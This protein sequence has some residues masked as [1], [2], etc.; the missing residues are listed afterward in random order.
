MRHL[1][2]STLALL[3][4]LI[5][6]TGRADD[7]SFRADV[8]A[9]T[10]GPHRLTG[11]PENAHA[12]DRIVE[13]L[14]AIGLDQ[15]FTQTFD[16]SQTVVKRCD[17]TLDGATWTLE[18]MRPNGIIP[19]TTPAA[20]LTGTLVDV[21]DGRLESYPATLPAGP[22]IMVMDFESGDA[23]RSAFRSG[24]EAVI[25]VRRGAMTSRSQHSSFAS[26]N[27][28]RFF[29]DGDPATL[30]I[31][32]SA[33]LHSEV[34]WDAA[35][36]RNVFGFLP[37]TDPVFDPATGAEVI[38]LAAPLDSFG[39]VP[40][41]SPGARPAA[42]CAAM[43]QLAEHLQKNRPRRH[44]LFA[45]FDSEARGH[46]GANAFYRLLDK[47]VPGL[48][49]AKR[50]AS[51]TAE[52]AFLTALREL[53]NRPGNPLADYDLS[54]DL[55]FKLKPIA[56]EH[57]YELMNQLSE[58]RA[59]RDRL[60]RVEQP[61]DAVNAQIDALTADKD[62]WN[63]T[64]RVIARGEVAGIAEPLAARL[65][66]VYGELD[67]Q[68]AVRLTQIAAMQSSI[69]LDQQLVDLLGPF[70][71]TLHLSMLLDD[72]SSRWG[73]VIGDTSLLA[74]NQDN[75]GLYTRVQS[76]FLK[77]ANDLAATQALTS[78]EVGSANQA[79]VP[80]H[81]ILGTSQFT[82]S[83]MVAGRLGLYNAALGTVQATFERDGT[84]DDTLAN[85]NLDRM[86]AQFGDMAPLLQGLANDPE[87]SMARSVKRQAEYVYS[88]F[89]DGRLTGPRALGTTRGSSVPT[90]PLDGAMIQIMTN[91]LTLQTAHNPTMIPAY[92]DFLVLRTDANGSYSYGPIGPAD[93][94]LSYRGFAVS[95]DP[96]GNVE[97]VNSQGTASRHE[98]RFNMVTC[99]PGAQML[100][101][102]FA[103]RD[104]KV[105]DG[106]TNGDLLADKTN[107]LTQ[108]G[109][110]GWYAEESTSK[111]KLFEVKTI[112]ALNNGPANLASSD[113]APLGADDK[114]GASNDSNGEGLL[115]DHS[116]SAEP[117]AIAAQT[118][119]DL[120]RLNESRL[121][122]LRRRGIMNSSMEELHGRAEDLLLESAA[123]TDPARRDALANS[124]F[125][126][127]QRT[128]GPIRKT[129]DDIVKAVLILLAL[130]VPFAFALERLLIGTPNIYRQIS[131]FTG[132]FLATFLLLYI[133]HPA[134]A[135]SKTPVVIFLGFTIVV[136]S[137]MVIVIIMQKFEQELKVLQGMESTVH[138]ADV[139]RFSTIM[140]AMSMGISTMRRRPLRT[141]LTATTIILLT[142]T[143]LGFASFETQRG[144]NTR[145]AQPSPTYSGAF[146]HDLNWN[147][148]SADI[149]EMIQGRWHSTGTLARRYW[150][151]PDAKRSKHLLLTHDDGT[152]PLMMTGL[153]GLDPQEVALR[154][155]LAAQLKP[156]GLTFDDTIWMTASAARQLGVGVG[157][158]VRINGLSLTV[159]PLL[160]PIKLTT[161]R[162]MDDNEILPVDFASMNSG[163]SQPA[164]QAVADDGDAMDAM[165]DQSFQSVSGD[166]SLIVSAEN[167][168]RLGGTLRAISLYTDNANTASNVA[169]ELAR[170]LPLPIAATR[171]DGVY[172]HYLG[173]TLQASGVKDLFFPILLG[174]MVIFGTMLG[175]VADREKEIYTF[176][177][178]G[179]AP[180][181]VAGLFFAEALIYSVIGGLGGYL[182]AQGSMK[183]LGTLA[184]FG[185][186]RVPEMN[187]S[188]TNAIITILLVMVTV[189]ISAIYPAIK[190]SRSANPGVMRSW[191]V[192]APEGD[193]L[194]LVFPFTVSEYDI[195]GVVSFLKEHF[196]TY[197][198]TG[199]GVFM[200][201]RADLQKRDDGQ[202]G[203]TADIALA[204]FDL[205]V[206]EHFELHSAPSEIEGIN[207]VAICIT[208]LSGQPK[209]WT[210]QTKTLLDDLRRQF[211]IW[212]SLPA[213]TMESYRMQTLATLGESP[214]T[215]TAAD[216][217]S[218]SGD[219]DLPPP[220]VA[221][222]G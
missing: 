20:G 72:Q 222:R 30:P 94:A 91:G 8:A 200:T 189:L 10:A 99:R 93:L 39:E 38:I 141:A 62:F 46:A 23:W 152:M 124:S 204:P 175:S 170:A 55:Q 77:A 44:I 95:F 64:R 159:G 41:R 132:F 85:L 215:G 97:L 221:A 197:S 42:N 136:L 207:E 177:A 28:P 125:L 176:S 166:A 11:S 158:R 188:S 216:R 75:P 122:L 190:A 40:T 178:L 195:T 173:V 156:D 71:V 63:D 47:E 58:L 96:Q 48:S 145:F 9:L 144:V 45:F 206:T 6:L 54:H 109:I 13:R 210:R 5:C 191:K 34:L 36:G 33:T 118:A 57:A 130:C 194:R 37:G 107:W 139:S 24:A 182:L 140:A 211:L 82:H 163:G 183:I 150:I 212:R 148:L 59:E 4:L 1:C 105:M 43:L 60:T 201:L 213:E 167:A 111:I 193:I 27:F 217:G 12:A 86:L 110:T 208:R 146:I 79:L 154:S 21:G 214:E 164:A 155:D 169:E 49:P 22:M 81:A 14:H 66:T 209:D 19:A 88:E 2:Y 119:A 35:T 68:L 117:T 115:F 142:F 143:I 186:V 89:G 165:S 162:D 219:G 123:S 32:K 18:P 137:T 161:L 199:L 133:S 3:A 15:V 126:L 84:P 151:A 131:W 180:P 129:L 203:L 121:D 53:M 80:A 25:F 116:V 134:F 127:Q 51:L 7:A 102:T 198:D 70:W 185:L 179:L 98:T 168:R 56:A 218:E 153:L 16:S 112:V 174:G 52:E 202:V 74:S 29:F 196:D 26:A 187:Y 92:D 101:V 149:F 69:A 31:G 17:L 128:Y 184:D 106:V 103:P 147:P 192:P 61:I 90:R 83:G 50:Q 120:W 67:G 104:V 87:L 113:T 73:L 157:D 108:D 205:G 138:A 114:A 171:N 100:P 181:H 76:R 65:K 135:I 78:F 172:M 220:T 160:D